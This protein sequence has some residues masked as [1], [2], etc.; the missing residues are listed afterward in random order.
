MSDMG[1]SL[2]VSVRLQHLYLQVN[3]EVRLEVFFHG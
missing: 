3:V 1:T 2:L